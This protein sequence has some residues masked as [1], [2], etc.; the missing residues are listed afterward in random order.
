MNP[1]PPMSAARLYTVP[2]PA[3]AFSHA[4][5]PCKSNCKFSTPGKTLIPLRA[6]LDIHRAD[7]R[8]ALPQQ[9]GHQMAADESAAAANH[10]FFRTHIIE[11][12]YY[13][14]APN[15]VQNSL[16]NALQNAI[17]AKASKNHDAHA[18]LYSL[19]STH[20]WRRGPGRGGSLFPVRFMGRRK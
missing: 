10:N 11:R 8:L 18:I 12:K 1:I 19:S 17:T 16:C 14:N 4:S 13:T 20:L 5:C 9:V 7:V 2:A 6:R 3:N 15:S